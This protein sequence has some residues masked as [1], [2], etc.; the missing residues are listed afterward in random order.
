MR[1][2]N[3][4]EAPQRIS[5]PKLCDKSLNGLNNTIIAGNLQ[6]SRKEESSLAQQ[7]KNDVSTMKEIILTQDNIL[8]NNNNT[9]NVAEPIASTSKKGNASVKQKENLFQSKHAKDPEVR[10]TNSTTLSNNY[11]EEWVSNCVTSTAQVLHKMIL[12]LR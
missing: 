2:L 7:K 11:C 5:T 3:G 10:A 1:Q 6:P 9:V 4:I 12:L 8:T